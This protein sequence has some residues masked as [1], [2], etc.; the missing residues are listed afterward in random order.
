VEDRQEANETQ[1]TDEDVVIEQEPRDRER[2]RPVRTSDVYGGGSITRLSTCERRPGTKRATSGGAVADANA[3]AERRREAWL[4]ENAERLAREAETRTQAR[5]FRAR[6]ILGCTPDNPF[7]RLFTAPQ[8][9]ALR[10]AFDPAQRWVVWTDAMNKMLE[11]AEENAYLVDAYRI[12]KGRVAAYEK[13]V[14]AGRPV[15]SSYGYGTEDEARA[16][17][18]GT[19]RP[20][21]TDLDVIPRVEKR[22]NRGQKSPKEQHRERQRRYREKLRAE[23]ERQV[24]GGVTLTRRRV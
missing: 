22:L 14:E 8:L 18:E 15:T 5:L 17:L 12:A 21:K 13:W 3:E 16:F 11:R 7:L 24:N 9:A 1:L 20:T 2:P 6:Y 4:K 23:K 10:L 19:M